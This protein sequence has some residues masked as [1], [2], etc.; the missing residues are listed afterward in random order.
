ME[1]EVDVLSSPLLHHQLV[2]PPSELGDS[3]SAPPFVCQP[4]EQAGRRRWR[5]SREMEMMTML[6]TRLMRLRRLRL[7][8]GLFQCL[9][10]ATGVSSTN[11]GAGQHVHME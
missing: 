6:M 7:E 10:A 1:L 9:A 2:K 8:L 5:G 11:V 4:L 3:L